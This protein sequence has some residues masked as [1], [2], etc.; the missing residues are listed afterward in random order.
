MDASVFQV[1]EPSDIRPAIEKAM[2][3][4]A[5]LIIDVPTNLEV[6]QYSVSP[7]FIYSRLFGMRGLDD[8]PF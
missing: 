2:K 1:K 5:P 8:P 3:A 6:K 4:E 7:P